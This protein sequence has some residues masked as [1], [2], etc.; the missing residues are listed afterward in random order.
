MPPAGVGGRLNPRRDGHNGTMKQSDILS[1]TGKQPDGLSK[2]QRQ[3]HVL[4]GNPEAERCLQGNTE[5]RVTISAEHGSRAASSARADEGADDLSGAR[6]EG[7]GEP[8]A[9][10][11]NPLLATFIHSHFQLRENQIQM[12]NAV[13][14]GSV[15]KRVSLAVL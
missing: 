7:S 14:E 15:P 10:S 12:R 2:T 13:V 11:S 8:P 5:A 4:S 1:K 6:W 9:L 3:S